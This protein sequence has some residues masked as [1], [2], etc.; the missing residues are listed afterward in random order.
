MC[1]VGLD[2]G[3]Q[4][5]FGWSVLHV[6]P[7]SQVRLQRG[8]S[9]NVVVA[10]D[11]LT[12]ELDGACPDAV[13]IDSPL[14]WVPV[15]DRQ[16]DRFVRRMVCAAGGSSGTVSHVNSLRGAC[17]VQGALAAHY[18]AQRWPTSLI[19]EAHP[20][21]LL[22]VSVAAREFIASHLAGSDD[23]HQRDAMLAAY[24]AW[25]AASSFV[26]WRDLVSDEATPFFP[27]GRQVS[28]WFPDAGDKSPVERPTSLKI[29]AGRRGTP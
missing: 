5:S 21:A 15:G 17:L 13:G 2:P 20:K 29:A 7:D 16:A 22:R 9:S 26:G 19:T 23:E 18:A 28:Y 6:D 24:S 12:A 25:A 27:A 10:I 3:G 11:C 4:A 8:T 1:F 14:F